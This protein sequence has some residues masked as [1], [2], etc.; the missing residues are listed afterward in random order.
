MEASAL[1][2]VNCPIS[3]SFLFPDNALNSCRSANYLK[4]PACETMKRRVHKN[5]TGAARLGA[6]R[7]V[8]TWG[9]Y[10]KIPVEENF[11]ENLT[12]PNPFAI[13]I[14]IRFPRK[15]MGPQ[16]LLQPHFID[17]VS[18]SSSIV[19][20]SLKITSL[21]LNTAASSFASS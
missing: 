11:H 12:L 5:T 13:S 3:L 18:S 17:Y 15:K 21:S 16:R 10:I 20:V 19:I 7:F 1:T 8:S 6:C 14:Y 9:E 2:P 4:S